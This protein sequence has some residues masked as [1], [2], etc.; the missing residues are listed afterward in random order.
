MTASLLARVAQMTR[1][2]GCKEALG[3]GKVKGLLSKTLSAVAVVGVAA[4]GVEAVLTIGSVISRKKSSR[5]STPETGA[6]TPETGAS[7]AESGD[8]DT[9]RDGL[10]DGD[11]RA[12][13]IDH[14]L[15]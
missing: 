4:V 13:A 3:L 14:R 5:A 7:S 8:S 11:S 15:E 9:G 6:S 2:F 10:R 12:S 1:G